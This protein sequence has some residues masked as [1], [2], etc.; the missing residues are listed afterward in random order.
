MNYQRYRFHCYIC[1]KINMFF[2][3]A[4]NSVGEGTPSAL[5]CCTTLATNPGQVLGLKA[6][7][8]VRVLNNW[9]K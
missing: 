2:H 4:I 5:T 1:I 8:K 6:L 3:Q 7:A 9:L